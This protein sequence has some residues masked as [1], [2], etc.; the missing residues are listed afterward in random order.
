MNLNHHWK[1]LSSSERERLAK[2]SGTAS[3][4][5]YQIAAGYRKPSPLLAQRIEAASNGLV[6]RQDLRP[7]V[8]GKPKRRAA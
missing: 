6:T 2:A 7:D 8:Y 4:Y 1:N 5:L 3:A